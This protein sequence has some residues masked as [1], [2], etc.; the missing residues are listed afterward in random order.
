[1]SSH[2]GWQ[3]YA[4]QS[5]FLE[6]GRSVPNGCPF[7]FPDF[8]CPHWTAGAPQITRYS[9]EPA[10]Y[11][12]PSRYERPSEIQLLNPNSNLVFYTGTATLKYILPLLPV[13]NYYPVVV[14]GFRIDGQ[15]FRFL[16]R[17]VNEVSK[18]GRSVVLEN[19]SDFVLPPYVKQ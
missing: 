2:W 16:D 18:S 10:I 8:E 15:S 6:Y 17:L 19:S 5:Y 3:F 11:A 13:T 9:T 4:G 12:L 14:T 7:Q 1:M